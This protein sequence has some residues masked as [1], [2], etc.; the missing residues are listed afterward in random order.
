MTTQAKDLFRTPW[1]SIRKTPK[2]HRL[3]LHFGKPLEKLLP[4]LMK[5]HND[6]RLHAQKMA[7]AQE[8]G[9]SKQT[10]YDWIDL[11]MDGK[12]GSS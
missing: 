6:K 1:G 3:E 10:I 4:E 12:G 9:V 7:A 11:F 8:L 5:K 2:M